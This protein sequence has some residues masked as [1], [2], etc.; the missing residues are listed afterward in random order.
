MHYVKGAECPIGG[1]SVTMLYFDVRTRAG[2]RGRLT[3]QKPSIFHFHGFPGVSW[4]YAEL[5][6]GWPKDLET[7]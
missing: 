1:K 3:E 6:L 5:E 2:G 4:N 7:V